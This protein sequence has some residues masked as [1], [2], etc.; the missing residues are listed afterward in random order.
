MM[1]ALLASKFSWELVLLVPQ[2]TSAQP[3]GFLRSVH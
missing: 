2:D 1:S 3:L